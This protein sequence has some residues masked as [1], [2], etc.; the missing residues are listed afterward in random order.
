MLGGLCVVSRSWR[1]RVAVV[2]DV[3]LKNVE[4][5]A[6][7]DLLAQVA[8]CPIRPKIED[9]KSRSIA[10]IYHSRPAITS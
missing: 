5:I 10:H 7:A 8:A 6:G 4:P 2:I 9:R 1:W 3:I